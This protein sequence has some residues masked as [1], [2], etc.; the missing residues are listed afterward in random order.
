MESLR[1]RGKRFSI[2]FDSTDVQADF[3]LEKAPDPPSEVRRCF[4]AVRRQSAGGF[5][6][7]KWHGA[8]FAEPFVWLQCVITAPDGYS[9]PPVCS[10]QALGFDEQGVR[11]NPTGGATVVFDS[12]STGEERRQ[13]RPFFNSVSRLNDTSRQFLADW[14]IRVSSRLSAI[15]GP[16]DIAAYRTVERKA[17]DASKPVDWKPADAPS[18]LVDEPRPK[19]PIVA[20]DFDDEIQRLKRQCAQ[21]SSGSSKQ[22]LHQSMAE[23]LVSINPTPGSFADAL[24]G[25]QPAVGS[26]ELSSQ[27][28]ETSTVRGGQD[29]MSAAVSA[30]CAFG[31]MA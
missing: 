12:F 16:E 26:D 1:A 2:L 18:P 9:Q 14:N 11:L 8:A 30:L 7:F 17:P 22:Q 19:R 31:R 25:S 29:E 13:W 28:S 24:R 20:T 15:L 6:C 27:L 21:L 10:Q 4:G 23:T 5:C 3:V